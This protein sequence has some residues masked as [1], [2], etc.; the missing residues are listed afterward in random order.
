VWWDV[1]VPVV[2]S[3]GVDGVYSTNWRCFLGCMATKVSTSNTVFKEIV[4][5]Q[6]SAHYLLGQRLLNMRIIRGQGLD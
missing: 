3:E 4:H 1:I 2:G 5:E 6:E